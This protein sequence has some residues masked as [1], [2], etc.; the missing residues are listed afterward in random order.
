MSRPNVGTRKRSWTWV[1]VGFLFHA[2]LAS[3][4]VCV[5]PVTGQDVQLAAEPRSDSQKALQVFLEQGEYALWTRDTVLAKGDTVSRDVLLLEATARIAGRVDGDIY[6]VDGDLFLRTEGSVG[7]DVVVLGGGFYDSELAEI[8]GALTY[9]PNEPVR[10]RPTGGDFE[11]VW[12]I[13]ERSSFI[14]FF[15]GMPTYQRVDGLT[16]GVGGL[17]RL[18]SL[19]GRPELEMGG[20]YKT[21]GGGFGD[22][23]GRLSWYMSDQVRIGFFGERGTRS[24]ESWSRPTWYNSL[25]HLVAGIDNRDY[26]SAEHIGAEIEL[27]SLGPASWEDSPNWS[28]TFGVGWEDAESLPA[29]DVKVLF[30]EESQEVSNHN[31]TVDDGTFFLIQS[32]FEW[33]KISPGSKVGFGFGLEA[34][35]GTQSPTELLSSFVMAEGRYSTRRTTSWGH[36]VNVFAIM[37]IDVAGTLPRQRYSTIGGIGTVPTIPL[38]GLRNPQLF[39]GEVTYAIPLIGMVDLG[40]LDAFL[41]A[42]G[43]T[44]WG[45]GPEFQ[46]EKALSAGVA[47]RIWDF[48]L[49]FGLPL[50]T[51]MPYFDVRV[52]RSARP[53]QMS[54]PGCC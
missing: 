44:V 38:R 35:L 12:E 51:S 30:G 28:W 13:E 43:G 1:R 34:G 18:A 10:V 42:S 36:L 4:A 27:S 48:Q 15:P 52:R 7:G 40:G 11:V 6:V 9:R 47:A 24:N 23:G 8:E 21:A 45:N 37:R 25:A 19:P 33:S 26:Y 22:L 54:R 39:F 31:P 14:G 16:V 17:G 32:G 20:A 2:I 41:R 29:R 5:T 46:L 53:S 3:I 49:E 50:G